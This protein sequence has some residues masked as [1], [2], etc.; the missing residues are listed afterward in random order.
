MIKGRLCRPFLHLYYTEHSNGDVLLRACPEKSLF[1]VLRFL[2]S[3]RND[4]T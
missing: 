4:K 3:V 1:A 2:P